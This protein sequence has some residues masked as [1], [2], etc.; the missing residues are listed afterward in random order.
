MYIFSH[1]QT[2][3]L[4]KGSVMTYKQTCRT[5]TEHWHFKCSSFLL[6][7]RVVIIHCLVMLV[8]RSIEFSSAFSAP[9]TL[10]P[11]FPVV[12]LLHSETRSRS[13]ASSTMNNVA[14]SRQCARCTGCTRCTGYSGMYDVSVYTSLHD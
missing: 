3:C 2:F 12:P 6:G 7:L 9:G 13:L 5:M 10:V 11:C 8:R 1:S 14:I 4:S